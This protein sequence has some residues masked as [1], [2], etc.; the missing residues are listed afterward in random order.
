MTAETFT[1][2]VK[3]GAHVLLVSIM[4][5]AN[6]ATIILMW[7]TCLST[8]LPPA[9]HPRLSQA[10]LLFPVFLGLDILFL[11]AWLIVSWKWIALPVMGILACWNYTRDYGPF[12]PFDQAP[13][14][15]CKIL[16][17]N[18]A[19]L[20]ND[21]ANGFN[22]ICHGNGN[23]A[24]KMHQFC[25]LAIGP[26]QNAQIDAN[27]LRGMEASAPTAVAAGLMICQ[28]D[29]AFRGSLA[30]QG[31]EV[32]IGGVDGRVVVKMGF[33]GVS[34]GEGTKNGILHTQSISRT[35][36]SGGL[37]RSSGWASRRL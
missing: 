10:G 1:S 4:A 6:I 21:S 24:G 27:A 5:G 11:L 3:H 15:S 20:S 35:I 19:S 34:R 26:K 25:G 12:N 29:G 36:S 28:Q 8:L 37:S 9:V 7:A 18:V 14:E 23:G 13:A 31:P 22:G 32:I 30:G 33:P 16:S 17:F 2:K